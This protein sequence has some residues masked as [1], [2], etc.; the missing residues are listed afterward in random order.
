MTGSDV[1]Q[2]QPEPPDDNH[3][4]GVNVAAVIFVIILVLGCVW[5]V[6]K[7]TSANDALNC[8]A[9]GRRNCDQI[10]R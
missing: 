9:S 1:T 7:L 4:G 10:S 2:Q 6:H 5:L 3:S 8:V